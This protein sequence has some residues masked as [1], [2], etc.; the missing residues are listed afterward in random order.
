MNRLPLI[1]FLT[2][3][4][5]F[6][7]AAQTPL[8]IE[9]RKN[10]QKKHWKT[11]P[12]M[13]IDC[14][15]DFKHVKS[16]DK[17]DKYGGYASVKLKATG[18]FRTEKIGD[19]WW[20]VDPEGHP[21]ISKGMAVFSMG[22]SDRQKLAFKERFGNPDTWAAT[23]MAML[24][25][26]GFNDLGAW[27]TVDVVRRAE[28]P[29]PYTVIVSPMG[30]YK[31]KH[32][33]RFGGKYHQA[34][35]QNYRFD[36]AMVFD[37]EFDVFVEKEMAKIAQYKDDPYL[38]GYFTDNEIPWKND[39]LDRHL[40][41]LAKDEAAYLAVKKW[42]DS[43]K[44]HDAQPSEITQEDRDAFLAFYVDTYLSKVCKALRQ[45]DT[46]HLYLGCRFNQHKEEL[47][48]KAVFEVAGRYMDV[49]SINHYQKWQP[50]AEQMASWTAW[51]GKPFLITEFYT[52]GEDSG[53]PNNTGAGWN[54]HT[55]A[56]RGW[57]YQ[58]F[59]MELLKSKCCIGWHWFKYMDND[60]Q[61]LKTDESNRDS[62]KGVVK[63][64]FE[65]YTV[66]LD[67]MKQLNDNVWSL[68]KY[69]DKQ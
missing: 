21:Y 47:V 40:N 8:Q 63:W 24:R 22:G 37:P 66:L 58:N 46:N 29:M 14:L 10:A 55:Q 16:G 64:N 31:A 13:T 9:S 30:R 59:T 43:R 3:C 6:S 48:S 49:I 26:Y 19:R 50:D 38:V 60:P 7:A 33:K 4:V 28:H 15:K 27:S 57:F 52:K 18:F 62:N 11:Y 36:L 69:F 1:L 32:L 61:N 68:I 25:S 56:D 12:T 34:G 39:A 2:F 65:P 67:E 54:V 17:L 5:G 23:E 51:S 20:L 45:I 41:L 53:L 44:G 35:W 42:F